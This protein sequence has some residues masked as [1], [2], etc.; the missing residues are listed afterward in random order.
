MSRYKETLFKCLVKLK[1][2]RYKSVIFRNNLFIE[3]TEP[4]YLQIILNE[5]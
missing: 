2:R 4:I 5:V 1:K 3:I